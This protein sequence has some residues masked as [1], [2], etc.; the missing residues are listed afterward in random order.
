MGE[1]VEK[2]GPAVELRRL[3]KRYGGVVALRDVSLAVRRGETVALLGDNGAGKSTLVKI[4]AGATYPSEGE[5]WLDGQLVAKNSPSNAMAHGV[6]TVYQNLNLI[7][8]FSAAENFFLGRELMVGGVVRPFRLLR[9][10]AMREITQRSLRELGITIPGLSVVPV[11]KMSGGQRQA[12]AVAKAV[13]D[14]RVSTLILDEPTAA[15]GVR[16]TDEILRVVERMTGGEVAVIVVSHNIEHVWRMCSRFVILRGGR[17][18]A[19]LPKEGTSPEE[20]VRNI[21]GVPEVVEA[22]FAIE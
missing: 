19:D 2:G 6:E 1:Y 16:E 20:I 13:H 18:V 17:L 7:E 12:I 8:S 3:A 11:S 21:I 5:V 4:I 14:E 10:R 15:L 9:K 22:G